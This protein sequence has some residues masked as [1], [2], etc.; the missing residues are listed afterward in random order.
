MI[1]RVE[2]DSSDDD[3]SASYDVTH[4]HKRNT[5]TGGVLDVKRRFRSV[6]L[7]SEV[8]NVNLVHAA[9]IANL[10]RRF[11][12]AFNASPEEIHGELQYPGSS[13]RERYVLFLRL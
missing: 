8:D 13:T 3:S 5:T 9:Q 6:Q 4:A 7:F 1:R 11:A 2:S 10:T 12:P